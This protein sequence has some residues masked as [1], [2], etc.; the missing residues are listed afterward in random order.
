MLA[1]YCAPLCIEGEADEHTLFK[2]PF[3]APAAT[4]GSTAWTTAA[5]GLFGGR[6]GSRHSLMLGMLKMEVVSGS[7]KIAS[8]SGEK[9]ECSIASAALIRRLGSYYIDV[10]D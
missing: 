10:F 3:A 7:V 1:A 8:S 5:V 6:P 2:C 4:D 9:Y